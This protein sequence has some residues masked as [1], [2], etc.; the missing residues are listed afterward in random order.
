TNA[1]AVPQL[2]ALYKEVQ[3]YYE[4][5]MRVPDDVTLLWC[6]DNWGNIRRLPTPQ[7]RSRSGGA[8]IYY[9]L[10]YV[11]GPR[12]YKWVNSS[13]LPKIWEQMNLAHEYGANRIWIVNVGHLMH[14]QLPTEFFLT[15]AWNPNR[16]PKEKI[17]EFTEL[18]AQRE[19]GKEFAPQIADIVSKF[20]KYNGRRKPELLSPDTFSLLNYNEAETVLADWKKITAEA[21]NIYQQLPANERD[22]FFELVL[23]PTKACEIV[24]ELYIDAAKNRLY[25]TQG[26]ASA[27]DF[28]ADVKKLF[29]ADADLSDYYNHKLANGK[30]NH[31]MDQ[32][33][34]GYQSWQQPNKNIMPKV[35]EIE[36]QTN[37]EMGVAIEGSTNSWPD[38]SSKAVLPEFDKFN[39]PS[40]YIDVFNKGQ[41]PFEFSVTT[42]APWIELSETNGT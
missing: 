38:S 9:H 7:E 20:T 1:A 34:I 24:N 19:F 23:Y 42:S 11:G 17:S 39:Q 29:Q 32:T 37:A 16:W 41:T 2:W 26:R 13:P 5:G 3:G 33:H 18:W 4:D 31:M 21:E 27:N 15:Y 10:D 22:A 30:W 8:G 28:A 12:N 6:D 35:E 25:A 40:R 36:I 14:V